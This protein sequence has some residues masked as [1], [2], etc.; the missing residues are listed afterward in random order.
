MKLRAGSA[1][2]LG[3]DPR[4]PSAPQCSVED[5]SPAHAGTTHLEVDDG[6][7]HQD[8]NALQQVTHHVDE[9]CTDAGA[10]RQGG[11]AGQAAPRALQLLVAPRA[12]AVDGGGLVQDV[13]HAAGS[14]AGLGLG[15]EREA[16]L[17]PPG[18]GREH[19]Q[20][21]AG[22]AQPPCGGFRAGRGF[23]RFGSGAQGQG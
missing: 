5:R 2:K 12:M 3:W 1:S 7:G 14:R 11:M 4:G 20:G 6:G 8:T 16:P 19:S 17:T 15:R 18:W 21:S 23:G 13:C 10:A 9:G 22:R